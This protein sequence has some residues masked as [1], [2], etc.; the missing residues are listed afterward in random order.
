MLRRLKREV[1]PELPP[2]IE[3][4]LHVTLTEDERAL[5]DAV[6]ATTQ[7]EIV[8]QLGQGSNPIQ[9]LAALMRLRQA[10]VIAPSCRS[11]KR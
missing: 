1:A 7:K 8:A 5:Y 11:R 4:V 10:S 2:K 9:A 3:T 6:R